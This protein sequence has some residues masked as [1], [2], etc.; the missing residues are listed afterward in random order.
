M[1]ALKTIKWAAGFIAVVILLLIFNPLVSVPAG[2]TGVITHFGKVDNRELGEGIHMRIPVYTKVTKFDNRVKK[3]EVTTSA[4]SRD[5]QT[6]TSKIAVNYHVNPN[7]SAELYQKVGMAYEGNIVTPAIHESIKSVTAKY[8]AEELISKR[9]DVSLQIQQVLTD[10]LE[11]YSVIIDKFNIVNF[12]FSE[13]FNTAIESKQAAEQRALQAQR[14]LER[15][16]IE[17]EQ[18]VATAKAQAEALRIQKE[19]VTPDLLK[20][21][22]I[23]NQK[24]AIEKWNGVLPTVTSDAVPFI[25]VK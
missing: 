2:H 10:K 17:A 15:I 25:S 3:S 14:D 6:V 23:E 24:M 11:I 12:D 22:E 18:Q 21:R 5:L 9:A 19:Q 4:A 1:N 7:A 8:T 13:S 16:K 20:L